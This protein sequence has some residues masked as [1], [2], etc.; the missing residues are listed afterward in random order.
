MYKAQFWGGKWWGVGGIGTL[1]CQTS[2]ITAST[3]GADDSMRKLNQV[4]NSIQKTLGLIH[5]FYLPVFTFNAAFQM[6]RIQRINGLVVELDN[7]V[8]LAEKSRFPVP[9]E[10]VN[11]I[12]DGKNPDEFSKDVI[13]RCFAKNQ[14]T[15]GKTGALNISGKHFLEELGQK[16]LDGE[17]ILERGLLQGLASVSDR[18]GPF[19]SGQM[20]CQ[21][22]G[23][24]EGCFYYYCITV[25]GLA[26]FCP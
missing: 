10:V 19:S 22:G 2:D 14:I 6:P 12:D 7:M 25:I 24:G 8:K 1:I 4:S 17:N 20:V 21:G 18:K 16:F 5:Q 15:Q 23:E 13:K 26:L 3:A 9:R 11:L